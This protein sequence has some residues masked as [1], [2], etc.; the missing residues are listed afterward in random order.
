M[1][2]HC[3]IFAYKGN[4]MLAMELIQFCMYVNVC[5][6]FTYIQIYFLAQRRFLQ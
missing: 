4:E 2:H 1:G 6:T 3:Y 5:E